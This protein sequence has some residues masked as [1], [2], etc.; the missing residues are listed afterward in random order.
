MKEIAP[1]INCREDG[2][3][4]RVLETIT[5]GV[6]VV[7]RKGLIVSL[8][9]AAENITGYKEREVRGKPCS[10]LDTD[11]CAMHIVKGNSIGCDLFKRGKVKN[12]SCQIK[13]KN[14][15]FVHLLKN[16]VLLK[17]KK[18][19][20]VGAVETM[21]DITSLFIKDM[22]IETL[23]QELDHEYGFMGMLGS[24]PLMQKVYEQIQDAAC[25][26]VPVNILGESGTGKELVA[27]AIHALSRRNK[28]AFVR[29]NCAALNEYLLE[30]ELFG[31][32]RGS[33]TGAISNRKGRFE[34]ANKGSLF[35][36]EIGD[37]SLSMQSK[38][39]RAL[40][41]KEIERIG[42][43]QPVKVDVRVITATNRDMDSLIAEG[44]FREDLFYR[45]N[46]FS[47]EL[48]PLRER[49]D[50]IPVLVSH[51]MKK[52]SSI[53]Q[54][55]LNGIS[56]EALEA[57]MSYHWPGN[58]RQ[59]MNVLEYGAITCKS[60]L[61][62]LHHLP[63]YLLG[64]PDAGTGGNTGGEKKRVIEALRQHKYNRTKTAE[65]LQISRVALWKKMKKLGISV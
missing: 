62:E 31:H 4:K 53:N 24:N 33:F 60:D 37:M 46:V 3:L 27:G 39:L 44:S 35:L 30:S 8:N 59:L 65:H 14:G 12:K 55:E 22:E 50:D 41:E 56:R 25:S 11:A 19:N 58:I 18:G 2:F 45:I 47:I 15:K 9:R 16:A 32:R 63:E 28:Q 23:R 48:P 51:Y 40:Q 1:K 7:D 34:A 6:M 52:I 57:L 20:T 36:D 17:D 29:L 38:L 43:N 42:D 21:T 61:M 26:D 54:K 10:I 5:D 13:G 64:K 49:A